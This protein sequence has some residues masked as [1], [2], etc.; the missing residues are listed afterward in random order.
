VDVWFYHHERDDP[1]AT[2]AALL[3]RSLER[4]WRA[5]VIVPTN[6]IAREI[7]A[8]LWTRDP[9]SFLPHGSAKGPNGPRQPITISTDTAIVNDAKV[10]F[11]MDGVEIGP[12][13]LE[14]ALERICVLFD[15]REPAPLAASRRQWKA[16]KDRGVSLS[17]QKQDAAGR[18][19]KAA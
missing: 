13:L 9:T 2:L 15:G 11:V 4:G 7:D 16:L 5:A 18:W 1:R 3:E 10:A 6:T 8:D 14:A 17:L 12:A 19:V